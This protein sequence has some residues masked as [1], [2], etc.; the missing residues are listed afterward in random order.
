MTSQ[1]GWTRGCPRAGGGGG[2][3]PPHP[4][5]APF[6]CL[7]RVGGQRPC[8]RT[9]QDGLSG[10]SQSVRDLSAPGA[11]PGGGRWQ[12]DTPRP[13]PLPGARQELSSSSSRGSCFTIPAPP[14]LRC[15]HPRLPAGH[16]TT[17]TVL[18]PG[19]QAQQ[20]QNP[21]RVTHIHSHNHTDGEMGCCLTRT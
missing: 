19:K 17:A 14:A 16:L 9:W 11:R 2:L 5:C 15:H 1:K 20:G 13:K 6:G 18:F 4:P 8:L 7:Y 21:D 10:P 12:M 3:S